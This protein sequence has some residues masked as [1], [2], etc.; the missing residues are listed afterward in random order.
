MGR[1]PEEPEQP[2]TENSLLEVLDGTVMMYSL[3]V[4]QQLGKVLRCQSLSVAR[5]VV[6]GAGAVREYVHICLCGASAH[7]LMPSS[8]LYYFCREGSNFGNLAGWGQTRFL[9]A[10]LRYP[11]V[12]LD[13]W[14]SIL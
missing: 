8:D 14:C 12:T 10:L 6:R 11:R 9:K 7:K 1:P 4:H 5:G 3:S 2:L 13:V